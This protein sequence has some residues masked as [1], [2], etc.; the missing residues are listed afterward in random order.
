MLFKAE[1]SW[2]DDWCDLPTRG[3]MWQAG[4]AKGRKYQVRDV[5]FNMIMIPSVVGD[6]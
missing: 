2:K 1:A 3:W 6:G 5:T 4:Y